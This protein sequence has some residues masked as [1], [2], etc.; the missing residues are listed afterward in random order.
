MV[1]S[2]FLAILLVKRWKQS[3]EN[4]LYKKTNNV[5]SFYAFILYIVIQNFCNSFEFL[6]TVK[7]YNSALIN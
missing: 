3:H 4:V 6:K 2:Y 7:L 1:L 5:L